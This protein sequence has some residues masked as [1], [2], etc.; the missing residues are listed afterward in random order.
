MGLIFSRKQKLALEVVQVSKRP[1]S[2]W[3]FAFQTTNLANV[4]WKI[5][6]PNDQI[7][8][9]VLHSKRPNWRT[10]FGKSDVQ[11]TKFQLTFCI[12]NDQIG[13]RR[14]EILRS[15]GKCKKYKFRKYNNIYKKCSKQTKT[16]ANR[17]QSTAHTHR[18]G[19]QSKV[20]PEVQ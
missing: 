1:H 10:S 13:E 6:R 18:R 2:N 3:R 20:T 5:R 12:P 17:T 16:R 4:V 8:I 9:D 14:L 11:T 15:F 7:P 19:F